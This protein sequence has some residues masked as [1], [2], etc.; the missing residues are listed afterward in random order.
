MR[1]GTQLNATLYRPIDLTQALPCVVTLTPYIAD[2]Y[3][4]RGVY[5]ASHGWPFLIVDV[6]GRGN[7]R[8][9]FRPYIQEAEDGHDV[10]EWVASQP[11]CNGKVALWGGSYGGYAQWVIAA[12]RP[13]HLITI[14]PV[15]APYMGLDFPMRNNVSYPYLIQW[16]TLTCGRAAQDQLFADEAFWAQRFREWWESGRPFRELDQRVGN[17]SAL[18]QEWVSHPEPGPYWDAYNP[19]TEQYRHLAIPIL[20]ITG[21]YDDD[22]PGALEH[23]RQHVRQAAALDRAPHYLIIGPWDHYRCGTPQAEF[24]GLRFG[25]ESLLDL[26]KLHLGWYAWTMQGAPRPEFLQKAVAYY[27]MGAERWRYAESLDLVTARYDTLFL[28][29]AGAANDLFAAG[30]LVIHP[31]EGG[32]DVFTHDPRDTHGPEAEAESRISSDSL[33]DQ[34]S[35]GARRGRQLVYHSAPFGQDTEVSGFFE[36]HVWLA[37]DCPDTDL[38]VSVYELTAEGTAIRLSTDVMRARY[39]EGLR[40]PKLLETREPLLYEFQ[41]FTFVSRLVRQGHRLRLVLAPMGR[42]IQASFTQRNFNTG[43][44][45]AEE[46]V[47]DARRVTVRLYHDA[48]RPSALRIPI[49]HPVAADDPAA[50][51]AAFQ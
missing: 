46:S 34:R 14:V 41:R 18:F 17:A 40:I 7:S 15:A 22:Q 8:G 45:V 23:Y 47:R 33:L 32:P 4:R 28:E 19:T 12:T 43:G 29:S 16:I 42:P 20:S 48:M 37:I 2:R 10:I 24:G 21:S 11:W 9:L 26:Q 6:R 13:S 30:A 1:D 31:R 5:F 44:V 49:G 27:V 35:H 51:E 38:Y 50:P 36:L 39:R 3:H 25:P